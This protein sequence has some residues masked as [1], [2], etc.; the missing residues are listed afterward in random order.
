MWMPRIWVTACDHVRVQGLYRFHC[1]VDLSGQGY[2]LGS[3]NHLDQD[4]GL[5]SCL[6]LWPYNNKVCVDVRG[7]ETIEGC[8]NVRGLG[9][10]WGHVS[11]Q[12][13]YCCRNHGG[14]DGLHHGDI[15]VQA[16]A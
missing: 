5:A 13:P 2:H 9:F 12:G 7:S 4:C 3:W 15:W 11:I 14:P 6:R 1:Q 10:Y 8:D 16:A